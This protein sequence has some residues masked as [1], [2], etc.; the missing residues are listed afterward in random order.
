MDT[1]TVSIYSDLTG[2]IASI[3]TVIST[4][5]LAI[6][7]LL[8]EYKKTQ[9]KYR[10]KISKDWTNEGDVS[11]IGKLTHY[12]HF[13][14]SVNNED[15]EITGILETKNINTNK[16]LSNISIIGKIRYKTANI[17]LV[18]FNR[19]QLIK[20]GKA[21]LKLKQNG[22]VVKWIIVKKYDDYFPTEAICWPSIPTIL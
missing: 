7:F 10:N 20:Y 14:L 15:G 2:S 8:K 6:Y 5:T 22:K 1:T 3:V 17:E 12:I 9:L 16:E 4:T 19:G 13:S 21:R 18:D 11:S